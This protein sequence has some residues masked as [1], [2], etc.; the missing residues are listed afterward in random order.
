MGL[1]RWGKHPSK[2]ASAE[3]LNNAYGR[4][5]LIVADT[6]LSTYNCPRIICFLEILLIYY[7]HFVRQKMTFLKNP[8]GTAPFIRAK[9]IGKI[10]PKR[11]LYFAPG[12]RNIL[13]ANISRLLQA[14]F[15]PETVEGSPGCGTQENNSTI[16]Q[17]RRV[18]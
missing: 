18:V 10:E 12:T 16:P 13:K 15:P 3:G 9:G 11:L 5:N 6:D 17:E 1:R 4:I 14:D 2:K 8:A 7:A